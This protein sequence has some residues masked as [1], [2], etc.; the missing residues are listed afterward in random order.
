MIVNCGAL[1]FLG[2]SMLNPTPPSDAS[3]QV[4]QGLND[5]TFRLMQ[6][7]VKGAKGN[8]CVSPLS[9]SICLSTLLEGAKG[10]SFED[11]RK[12]LGYRGL[13]LKTIDEGNRQTIDALVN[14]TGHPFTIANS[15]WTDA[16]TP[17]V[18]AYV[19]NAKAFYDSE[20]FAVRQFNAGVIAR[21]NA[22]TKQK[23]KGR[24]DKILDQVTPGMALVLV[25]ALTFDA[26]WAEK[27]DTRATRKQKFNTSDTTSFEVPMMSAKREIPYVDRPTSKAIRLAYKGGQFSMIFLVPKRGYDA[28]SLLRS[29]TAKTFGKTLET[30][31]FRRARDTTIF[32]PKF[33]I[34]REYDLIPALKR[35]GMTS[36]FTNADL[37]GISRSLGGSQVSKV[38]H[39]T[40][41][42]IDEKGTEAAAATGVVVTKAAMGPVDIFRADRPFAYM[43]VNDKTKTVLFAGVC[44]KP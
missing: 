16:G 38:V 7:V 5:F 18:P 9:I 3:T 36:L 25:N 32:I 1:L 26:D 35:L 43:L 12:T 40:Y 34:E 20:I 22:W 44:A 27:F 33:K 8:E 10:S 21:I 11:L 2:A 30:L 41:F 13:T 19:K 42:K 39:K 17:L 4:Q 31:E 24:I 6:D 28:R 15:V 23:T 29:M 37:S 14:A